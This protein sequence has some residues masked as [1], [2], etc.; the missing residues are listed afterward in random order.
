MDILYDFS[1]QDP[2]LSIFYKKYS[3]IHSYIMLI[4]H[5]SST[6]VF[7]NNMRLVF[8]LVQSFYYV[9]LSSFRKN[10][11]VHLLQASQNTC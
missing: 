6:T 2:E 5:A 10:G 8:V 7:K 9:N 1:K 11:T 3:S 4:F